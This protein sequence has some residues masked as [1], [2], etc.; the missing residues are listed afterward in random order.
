MVLVMQQKVG[1]AA[2]Q[3]IENSTCASTKL[4][5]T[6]YHSIHDGVPQGSDL[7]PLLSLIYIND[8]HFATSVIHLVF[9]ADDMNLASNKYLEK[10]VSNLNEA[11]V[12]LQD[13]FQANKLTVNLTKTKFVIFDSKQRL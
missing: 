9:Y 13:W 2:T 7:G 11:L 8:S 5:L 12:S 4:I 6:S 3:M 10:S 1:L